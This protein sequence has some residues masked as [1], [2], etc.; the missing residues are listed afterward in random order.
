[1][2]P[3]DLVPTTGG[4]TLSGTI[5]DL[6]ANV[7][8]TSSGLFCPDAIGTVTIATVT[9]G[10]D[11]TV[12]LNANK[13]VLVEVPNLQVDIVAPVV[14]LTGGALSIF[15]FVFNWFNDS[16]AYL[17]ESSIET[18]VLSVLAPTIQSALESFTVF[19]TAFQVPELLGTGITPIFTVGVQPETLDFTNTG[20]AISLSARVTGPGGLP[21]DITSEGSLARGDCML[22]Q[23]EAELLL[24]QGSTLSLGLHD[25]LLN[26]VLFAG[27]WTGALHRPIPGQYI[28]NRLGFDGISIT[29]A[30][31]TPLTPP[32]A[33][34]CGPDGQLQLQIADLGVDVEM[35]WDD[36][37]IQV[38]A[39]VSAAADIELSAVPGSSNGTL[40]L[41]INVTSVNTLEFD[42]VSATGVLDG[43]EELIEL[44]FKE[45][46]GTVLDELIGS[47]LGANFPVPALE[48]GTLIPTIPA[49][50]MIGFAPTAFS[51]G[52]GYTVLEGALAGPNN[53]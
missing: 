42:I 37:P 32:V 36:E 28:A 7:A 19:E 18:A 46:V 22:G 4:L 43:T 34:S 52:S 33:T 25:D 14:D 40:D 47:G 50:A 12:G 53:D 20:A 21:S 35:T 3:V 31:L 16:F 39:F 10:A 5:T 1:V 49:G 48:L 27:W 8:A 29:N 13:S 38:S 6:Q 23:P 45:L 30:I 41:A 9:L 24:P 51:T 44:F 26:Q 2:G 17:I 15:D 11:L